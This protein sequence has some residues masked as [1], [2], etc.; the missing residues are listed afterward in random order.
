[1]SVFSVTSKLTIKSRFEIGEW[2]EMKIRLFNLLD[3]TVGARS[4][5]KGGSS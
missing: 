4:L 3:V 1:M 2:L 5:P